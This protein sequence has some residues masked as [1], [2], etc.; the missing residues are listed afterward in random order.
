MKQLAV[1]MA[2]LAAVI[3]IVVALL[4]PVKSTAAP[5]G[6]TTHLTCIDFNGIPKTWSG[7]RGFVNWDYSSNYIEVTTTSRVY[8]YPAHMCIMDRPRT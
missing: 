2:L 3:G 7:P 6:E 1:P 5:S 4:M 8:R